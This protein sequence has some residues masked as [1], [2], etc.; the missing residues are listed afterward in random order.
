MRRSV[1]FSRGAGDCCYICRFFGDF[2]LWRFV[3]SSLHIW[4]R[5]LGKM[6]FFFWGGKKVLHVRTNFVFLLD[7]F[8][9]HPPPPHPPD[10]HAVF[11][12]SRHVICVRIRSRTAVRTRT[13]TRKKMYF[14]FLIV[15]LILFSRFRLW[16]FGRSRVGGGGVRC[17][18]S[19]TR[20]FVSLGCILCS[21][22]KTAGVA[23]YIWQAFL[24][25]GF[26]MVRGEGKGGVV[27]GG[28]KKKKTQNKTMSLSLRT[29]WKIRNTKYT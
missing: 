21:S 11:G 28:E 4:L 23:V 13:N 6:F 29:V 5:R 27:R 15:F 14:F 9:L 16:F 20:D 7:F 24:F 26:S 3:F 2:C 25:V 8:V 17:C 1:T 19:R 10:R 18:T 22:N 12:M